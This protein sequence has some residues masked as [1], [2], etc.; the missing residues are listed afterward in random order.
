MTV[1][2]PIAR[3]DA[4]AAECRRLREAQSQDAEACAADVRRWR[5]SWA[6]ARRLL[7]VARFVGRLTRPRR[8]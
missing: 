7:R 3:R 6:W 4:L 5:R 8:A 1:T 2:D